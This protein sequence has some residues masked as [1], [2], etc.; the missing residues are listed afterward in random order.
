[1]RAALLVLLLC[2]LAAAVEVRVDSYPPGVTLWRPGPGAGEPWLLVGSAPSVRFAREWFGASGSL[3]VQARCAG[4][5]SEPVTV[6]WENASAGAPLRVSLSPESS[7]VWFRDG[8]RYRPYG[9]LLVA[10]PLAIAGGLAWLAW[11]AR[12]RRSAALGSL[13]E[14]AS[15]QASLQADGT[16]PYLG[17]QFGPYLLTQLL[18]VGGMGYVYRASGPDGD[19]ALKLIRPEFSGE[20]EFRDRFWREIKLAGKL[21]HRGI[22]KI[23]SCDVQDGMLYYAME[24]ISGRDLSCSL[25]ASG[26][27]VAEA[28]GLFLPILEALE[29][30]HKAGIVHRDLK[31]S[32][33]LLEDSGRVVLMDFGLAKSPD[34]PPLTATGAALG[35]PAYMAPEQ[36]MGQLDK[37]SDQY[38]MGIILYELLCGRRPFLEND[39]SVIWKHVSSDVPL[40]TSFRG[41]LPASLEAIVMRML[42]KDPCERFEELADVRV[43]LGRV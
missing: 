21:N 43:A 29:V 31:P 20:Q 1:M 36:I 14:L 11:V 28:L 30:A 18:G 37:R 12:R 2:G 41:D 39:M 22:V 5:R 27:P 23:L 35:T 40:P 9:L 26:L 32:N 33:V 38:A 10:V 15:L 25:R 7:W 13:R 34:S 3:I 42:A 17:K 4:Y 19:V 8:V 6:L 24:L 16:N